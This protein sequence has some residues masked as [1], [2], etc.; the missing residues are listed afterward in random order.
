MNLGDYSPLVGM[1]GTHGALEFQ[2]THFNF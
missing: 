2:S 1:V